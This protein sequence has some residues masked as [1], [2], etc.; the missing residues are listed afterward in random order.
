MNLIKILWTLFLLGVLGSLLIH[1]YKSV[2]KA[3]KENDN[4]ESESIDLIDD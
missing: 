2:I 1:G 3:N 4:A